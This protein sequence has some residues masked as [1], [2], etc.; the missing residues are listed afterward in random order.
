M[1]SRLELKNTGKKGQVSQRKPEHV[2]LLVPA[3]VFLFL[4]CFLIQFCQS[5]KK[6]FNNIKVGK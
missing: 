6:L 2:L 1:S 5:F 4:F 3:E